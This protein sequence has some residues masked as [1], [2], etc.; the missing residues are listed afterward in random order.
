ML[1]N[2]TED[3]PL[4]VQETASGPK[5]VVEFTPEERLTPIEGGRKTEWD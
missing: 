3:G 4:M 1:K 5:V 2:S